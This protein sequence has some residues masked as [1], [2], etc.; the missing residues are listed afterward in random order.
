M[1]QLPMIQRRPVVC[2]LLPTSAK[3]EFRP[4]RR[5]AVSRFRNRLGRQ[6]AWW[7]WASGKTSGFHYS[8]WLDFL[9]TNRGD[10]AIRLASRDLIERAFGREVEFIEISWSEVPQVDVGRLIERVDL[11]II[12]GGGYYFLDEEQRLPERIKRDVMLLKQLRCP[13]VALCPG[14]NRS[15]E[16]GDA[17]VEVLPS[18][19]QELLS[20][21]LKL[22]A[23]SSV[24]D[25]NSRRVLEQIISQRTVQVAD[26]AL[27]LSPVVPANFTSRQDHKALQIGLNIAF[28]GPNTSQH[29]PDRVRVVA[30]AARELAQR[31]PC[32]F[33]YFIHYDSERLI[34]RLV[35]HEGLSL[36]VVDT[37]RPEELLCWYGQLDLHIC[38]MLH[39]SILSLNAGVPTINLS[40]DVKNAAFFEVMGLNE[41]CLPASSTD[42]AQLTAI[43][44]VVIN[45]SED[46][47]RQ[48]V[49]RKAELREAMDKFLAA[50]VDLTLSRSEQPCWKPDKVAAV[51]HPSH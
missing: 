1:L 36:T 13:V 31:R 14:I 51:E 43:I 34:P 8:T 11:F 29:M 18:E 3:T 37:R 17:E 28:H 12:G 42:A 48:I 26:P 39:S 10:I 2:L 7:Q 50:V 30:A 45:R 23:L 40:Y 27:F 25:E 24:R 41:Y 19:T 49:A 33:F 5:G 21:L 32:Q 6:I 9:D 20:E 44:N 4:V 47:R 22:L 15:V 35:R 16:P 46:L 38:Q